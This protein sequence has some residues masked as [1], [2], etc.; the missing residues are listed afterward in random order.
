M[1][2]SLFQF[3]DQAIKLIVEIIISFALLQQD[4]DRQESDR[5]QAGGVADGSAVLQNVFKE[6]IENKLVAAAQ[7]TV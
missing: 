4:H 5:E 2:E 6:F 3:M 1:Y 7:S